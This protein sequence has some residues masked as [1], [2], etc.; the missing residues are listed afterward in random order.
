MPGEY[1]PRNTE[2]RMVK[3]SAELQ[4]GERENAQSVQV[5]VT[6]DDIALQVIVVCVFRFVAENRG[7]VRLG[8]G[9]VPVL[10][11]YDV[12]GKARFKGECPGTPALEI[13]FAL[14]TEPT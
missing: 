7:H 2:A 10:Q 1:I 14:S 9:A 12:E 8:I 6:A 3:T 13:Q 11:K 5:L 4:I